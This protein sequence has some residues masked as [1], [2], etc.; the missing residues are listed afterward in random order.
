MSSDGEILRRGLRD[1]AA[2]VF[3]DSAARP[4]A[5][6]ALPDVWRSYGETGLLS[7]GLP[8]RFGGSALGAAETCIVLEEAGQAL[9]PGPL[10]EAMAMLPLIAHFPHAAGAAR[11]LDADATALPLIVPCFASGT[12]PVRAVRV[13]DD[14]MLEGSVA[15]VGFAAQADALMVVADTDDGSLAVLVPRGA[16]GLAIEPQVGIDQRPCARVTFAGGRVAE[17]NIHGTPGAAAE[18][19]AR[20]KLCAA[21]FQ[22]G[23]AG[24][25]LRRTAD[26]VS[27][28]RQF[29]APLAAKQAVRQRLAD[30]FID[31]EAMRSTVQDAAAAFDSGSD[32]TALVATAHYWAV[33]GGHRVVHAAQHL[34]GGIGA[35][36]SYPIH[37]FFLAAARM[38]GVLG[39][40]EQVLAAIGQM[41]A[42]DQAEPLT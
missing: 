30:A 35:D 6:D 27:Q 28:R 24:E 37:R 7:V 41:L 23:I 2:R 14:W 1:L 5:E 36:L 31:V 15:A 38:G 21:A 34:H 39:G 18:V 20:T 42:S 40:G 19:M 25:A 4:D 29:G 10:P 12:M 32:P 33:R 8:E 17:A 3:A 16:D 22:L 9:A 13:D 26:Y 11:W